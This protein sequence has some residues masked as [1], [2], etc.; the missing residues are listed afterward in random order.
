MHLPRGGKPGAAGEALKPVAG[1]GL[2]RFWL[3]GFLAVALVLLAAFVLVVRLWVSHDEALADR[4][5]VAS[6]EAKA[7]EAGDRVFALRRFLGV[8]AAD[9]AL[10]EVLSTKA[11][12]RLRAQEE[13]M[14]RQIPGALGVRL[15]APNQA[16]VIVGGGPFMSNAAI[17][18]MGRALHERDP[19]PV[20]VHR[21]AQPDMHLAIASA[22]LDQPSGEPIG[23]VHLALPF[24]MLPAIVDDG[25]D[26]G[27][28]RY[29]QR[30]GA[31]VVTLPLGQTS[32]PQEAVPAHAVE[33]PGTALRVAGWADPGGAPR[34]QVMVP[35]MMGYLAVLILVAL[36][37]WLTYRWLR[38]SLV[39]DHDGLIALVGDVV[40]RR[41]VR[42]YPCRIAENRLLHER[43]LALLGAIPPSGGPAM[44]AP[45]PERVADPDAAGNGSAARDLARST[46]VA[47]AAPSLPAGSRIAPGA[48]GALTPADGDRPARAGDLCSVTGP[49]LDA[50][51]MSEI[52]LVLG[53]EA[54][55]LGDGAVTVARDGRPPSEVLTKALIGGL[56]AG[57]CQVRDLGVAPTPLLYFATCY[58]GDSTGVMVTAGH[59]PA[60][61]AGCRI[62][63]GGN[64]IAEGQLRAVRQRTRA[65]DLAERPGGGYQ[66]LDLSGAYL[67][68]VRRDV[69]VARGLK[70]V[71]DGGQGAAAVLAP[72]LYRRLGCDVFELHSDNG[73]GLPDGPG[74]DPSRAD[75]LGPLSAAVKARGAD[76][77]LAL[78]GNGDR[79]G[80][81]DSDGNF[82]AMDR[83]LM[84]FAADVLSRQPGADIV[85]DVACTHLLATQIRRCGGRPVMW[86]SGHAPLKAKLRET[87]ALLAGALS[88]HVVFQERWLG[89]C[90]AIYAGA[91]LLELLALD[92]R[93]SAELF[94]ALPDAVGTSEI[95]LPLREGEAQRILGEILK[96]DMR[97]EG[98]SI[99]TIDGLRADSDRG[100][101]LVRFATTEPGLSFRFQGDDQGELHRMQGLIRGLVKRVA[102]ALD[103]PF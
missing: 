88:G 69:A 94:A 16:G 31:N 53:S 30:V 54:A 6:V 12:A 72:R 43:L 91:R 39:S 87:G 2:A 102:P 65:P 52:G 18:L 71:V 58:Q 8:W 38:R 32:D 85:Y 50:A 37:L 92:L 3:V 79:L 29:Q 13:A 7:R 90:D 82:I 77:G 19:S 27:R 42:R 59:N 84:L 98:V 78:D 89:F 62:V 51:R 86:Q 23:V 64:D 61:Q 14:V 67:E 9:P 11:E 10:R 45:T 68:R 96:L 26:A 93:P 103:L 48:N 24:S 21:V 70:L 99:T 41:A 5:L 44:A 100:W 101:G 97:A 22:V 17:D 33:I 20:E 40:A 55:G 49:E 95:L 75:D 73:G 47:E 36:A 34:T 83:V 74:A 63:V 28:V 66:K 80:V 57:G 46:P 1:S 35:A 56:R 15:A 25:G 81:V 4:Q 76:L 60:R